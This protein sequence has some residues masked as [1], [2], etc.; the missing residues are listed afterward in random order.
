MSR[1]IQDGYLVALYR[2]AT[3][4]NLGVWDWSTQAEKDLKRYEN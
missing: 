4:S 1:H 3:R 2:L